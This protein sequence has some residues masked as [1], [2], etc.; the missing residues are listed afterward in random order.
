MA[1]GL[2]GT[3]VLAFNE[4]RDAA[5][6]RD[7]ADAEIGQLDL[8]EARLELAWIHFDLLTASL[9]AELD[10][11]TAEPAHATFLDR[12]AE[13]LAEVRRLTANGGEVGEL[14][15]RQLAI[16]EEADLDR[17]PIDAGFLDYLHYESMP[18]DRSAGPVVDRLPHH[19]DGAVVSMLP[20]LVLADALTL[21]LAGRSQPA[22]AWAIDYVDQTSQIAIE[23][24]GWLGPARQAPATNHVIAGDDTGSAHAV[25]AINRSI[26]RARRPLE[27]IWD[28]DQWIIAGRPP[29]TPAPAPIDVLVDD[30]STAS[31][32]VRT[33]VRAAIE[34]ERADVVAASPGEMTATIWFLTAIASLSALVLGLTA[35]LVT[36]FRRHRS[37]SEVAYRDGLTGAFN[38]RFLDEEV[39]GWCQR[40]DHHVAIAMVDLDRFKLINDTWG[41]AVGDAVLVATATRLGR[42]GAALFGAEHESVA[43]VRVGGD[44]FAVAAV[45]ETPIDPE[46]LESAVRSIA[47][48]VDAGADE[49]VPLRV[50]VGVASAATPAELDDLMR[51]AD[52]AVYA[53]KGTTSPTHV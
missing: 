32:A 11:R 43:V 34:D 51:A 40:A 33:G 25:P 7:T 28:Y 10:G 37:L 2:A 42:A 16:H 46:M 26:D 29:T 27:R 30:T 4:S 3:T 44:E 53:A 52:L 31:T 5:A 22:P 38:R 1:L 12:R 50:S 36:Q 14:A 21:E 20:S 48:P 13:Q 18:I 8:V 47:G 9:H 49:P 6:A 45:S 17:W 24:P 35:A 41:H 23:T 39:G 19:I 15:S